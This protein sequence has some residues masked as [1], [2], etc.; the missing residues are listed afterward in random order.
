MARRSTGN[1]RALDVHCIYDRA[2]SF[3][4]ISLILCEVPSLACIPCNY[5]IYSECFIAK[6][7][8][9]A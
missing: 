5:S 3:I 1:I 2:C 6:T 9:P 8:V 7:K 4:H